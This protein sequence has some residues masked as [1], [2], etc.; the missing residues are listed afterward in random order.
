MEKSEQNFRPHRDHCGQRGDSE[1]ASEDI[2]AL[3]DGQPSLYVGRRD[4]AVAATSEEFLNAWQSRNLRAG[5]SRVCLFQLVRRPHPRSSG[6]PY[7]NHFAA[8][9]MV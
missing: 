7:A 6:V 4:A 3:R 9:E 2:Q 5:I 1:E 8:A